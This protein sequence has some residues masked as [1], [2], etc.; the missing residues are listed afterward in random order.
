MDP[1]L[2]SIHVHGDLT[3]DPEALALAATDFGHIVADRPQAVLRPGSATDIG[4]ILRF[5]AQ[6]AI[7]VVPRGCG[8]TG[9]GQA[10][11][12]D[13]IV[14]D[15]ARLAAIG[16]IRE[17]RVTVEA[18]ATWAD[19]LRATL[20]HGLTPPVLTDY[21]DLT[22]GGTLSVG[23]LGGTSHRYGAQTDTVL[24]LDA[25]TPDGRQRGCST[26]TSAELFHALLAGLGQ[27]GVITRATLRL[28]PAPSRV[29]RYKLS[30]SG[31][32]LL[33]EMQRR[34]L[35]ER[36][37]DHLQGQ[38]VWGEHGWEYLLD[39]ATYYTP[40]EEPDDET[41]LDGLAPDSTRLARE[42]LSYW[43]FVDRLD[44]SVRELRQTG[45]WWHPHP[46]ANLLIPDSA[47]DGFLARLLGELSPADLGAPGLLL[48]YPLFTEALATPLFRAPEESVAFLVATLGYAP[49]H[50][51]ESVRRLIDTNRQWYEQARELG[52]TVYPVGAI[53]F[54]QDDFVDHYGPAWPALDAAKKRFDP[55]QILG[56]GLCRPE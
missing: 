6:R 29:R 56:S 50:D 20:R 2:R 28:V 49:P 13:G 36:R 35:H 27:C 10:Q 45:E 42:D 15:M 54:G 25:I 17:D 21:L 47:T 48:V 8:H 30:Y 46:W 9:Y 51:P 39:A 40:P 52:G 44:D 26:T 4:T 34:L 41:T 16:D 1:D 3:G 32:R 53:P 23:G 38:I 43:D 19:V 55:R 18:G 14:I 5:A 33:T 22:V 12:R 7:P 11:A 37:F 24:A 31:V